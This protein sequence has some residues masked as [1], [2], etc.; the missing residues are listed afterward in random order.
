[1]DLEKERQKTDTQSDETQKNQRYAE[2]CLV[3]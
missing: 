1:M 2:V 3:N